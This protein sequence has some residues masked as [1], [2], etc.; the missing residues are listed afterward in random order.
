M[1]NK[2]FILFGT[3]LFAVVVSYTIFMAKSKTQIQQSNNDADIPIIEDEIKIEKH[4]LININPNTPKDQPCPL[5]GKMFTLAEK[6]AWS[7]KRPIAVMIE[8]SPDARPQS[9]LSRADIVFEAIAESGV[10]RFMSIFYCAAQADDITV[11]PVRSARTYFI[12]LASG[13]NRPLYAHVGGANIS[14]ETN[15]LG[16]IRD[17]GWQLTTDIDNMSVG[18]PTFNRNANR[19]AGKKVAT[20]HTM[21]SSTELLW[22]VGSKRGW[23]N[24]TPATKNK[25]NSIDTEWSEAYTTWNFQDEIAPQGEVIN[26]EYAFWSGYEAEYGVKWEYDKANNHYKRF[27]ASQPHTDLNNNEQI[28]VN[29]VIV[30][31]AK[32]RGPLNE[33]KHMMYEVIGKNKALIF[34]NGQV[35]EAKWEKKT[36]ESQITF[37]DTK[38]KEIQFV[39]GPLWISVV[40]D[41][42]KVTY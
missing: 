39:R 30:M 14:G 7:K 28:A 22:K 8:N 18:Y 16:Q 31:F 34:Y 10:T 24:I 42:N 9:G 27:L 35:V 33:E 3:Y 19:I 15:A 36:R 32:E 12:N 6:E 5:N 40:S 13:F 17:Y 41:R 29:N 20:E 4:G 11:A 21:V 37:T 23:T 38:G 1:K 25:K 26:I 2:F